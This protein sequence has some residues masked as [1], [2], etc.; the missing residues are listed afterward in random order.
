MT[1][2]RIRNGVDAGTG[3]GIRSIA[4]GTE[5]GMGGGMEDVT[6][7]EAEAEIANETMRETGTTAGRE[8]GMDEIRRNTYAFDVRVLNM[9]NIV[10][11][12][13]P[14]PLQLTTAT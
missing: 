1:G 8:E 7:R 6:R 12:L 9:K 14:L 3:T 13:V 11:R 5:I 10:G 4:A 2:R